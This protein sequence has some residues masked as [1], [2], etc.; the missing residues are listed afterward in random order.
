MNEVLEEIDQ[1][2]DVEVNNG[3]I[4]IKNSSYHTWNFNEVCQRY[5]AFPKSIEPKE[6]IQIPYSHDNGKIKL[7]EKILGLTTN[8]K[9]QY[10]IGW[11]L[12]LTESPV[13]SLTFNNVK[14]LKKHKKC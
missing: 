8:E 10:L 9:E 13:L 14:V 5:Y 11:E 12:N 6:Q 7:G 2:L 4:I 3:L 1:I